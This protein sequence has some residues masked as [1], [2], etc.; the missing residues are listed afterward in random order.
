[1]RLMRRMKESLRTATQSHEHQRNSGTSL[2][3]A[4]RNREVLIV[5]GFRLICCIAW[6]PV[7]AGWRAN[8]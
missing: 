6:G 3:S 7:R 4:T 2:N 5:L 1:M 8:N